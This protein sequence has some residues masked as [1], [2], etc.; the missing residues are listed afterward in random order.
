M[1]REEKKRSGEEKSEGKK[2]CRV[3]GGKGKGEVREERGEVV[4]E[5]GVRLGRR[6]CGLKGEVCKE[7]ISIGCS[8]PPRRPAPSTHRV[9]RTYSQRTGRSSYFSAKGDG[10]LGRGKWDLG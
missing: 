10:K 1:K 3:M 9:P 2:K 6:E 8:T 4:K 7:G 5:S